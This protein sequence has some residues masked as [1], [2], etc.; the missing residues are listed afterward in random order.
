MAP[1]QITNMPNIFNSVPIPKIGSNH[2]DLSHDFKGS[3]KMGWLIPTCVMETIPGDRFRISC[4]NMI[5]FAPMLAPVMDR[6]DAVIDFYFVP[7]RLLWPEWQDWITGQSEV[8]VPILSVASDGDLDNSS[9]GT[10]LGYQ[11][12]SPT[13]VSYDTPT[14][15]PMSALPLAAYVK[16]WDDFY[17]DQNLQAERFV[18]L[19]PGLQ[20]D[21][22][23]LTYL[24]GVPFLR[25]WQHDYFTAALPS[26]QKGTAV[27]IPLTYQNNIPVLATDDGSRPDVRRADDLNVPLSGTLAGS[28]PGGFLQVDTGSGIEPATLLL[29]ASHYVDVQ[30]DATDINTLRRAYRLQEFLERMMRGGSR[31]IEVLKSQ[32]GVTSSDARLQRPE[33]IGRS[34]QRVTISEVLSTAQTDSGETPVTTPVGN[35]AG[36]GISVGAGQNFSYYCE[37]HGFIIGI[38]NIQPRTSYQQGVHKMFLRTNYLDYYWPP[39]ANIGEQEVKLQ[40]LWLGKVLSP[41]EWDGVF[42]YVPRYAEY[43]FHNSRVVGEM[44]D[45]LSYWHLG[46]IFGTEPADKPVLNE[47]FISANPTTRI[48]AVEDEDVHNLYFHVYNS[49]SAIRKM[50]KFGVPTI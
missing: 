14:A 31:M 7:N 46:R 21:P 44:R 28:A 4:E 1:F 36:H 17:R 6:C 45:S 50:P 20:T 42:G 35:M 30:S 27:Q 32:F 49:I 18:D 10:Y 40:E 23:W 34:R 26:A 39:F 38:M 33:F 47:S 5:R 41:T 24:E 29:D 9:L 15:M 25:A 13:G 22:D 48:F 43:K 37:E 8:E 11:K 19:I 12:P 2:F 3:G 16:V